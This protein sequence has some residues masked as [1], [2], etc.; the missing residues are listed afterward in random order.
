MRESGLLLLPMPPQCVILSTAAVN[1]DGAHF[2]PETP[3]TPY[4]FADDGE[5]ESIDDGE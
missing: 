3:R 2:L 5:V 1:V 4:D